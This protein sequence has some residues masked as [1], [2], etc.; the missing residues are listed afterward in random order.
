MILQ[1]SL[2]GILILSGFTREAVERAEWVRIAD[3]EIAELEQ[4][5]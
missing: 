3:A 4:W 2:W 5:K 1:L